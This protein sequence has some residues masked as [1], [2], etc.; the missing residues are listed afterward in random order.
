VVGENASEPGEAHGRHL[1]ARL[2]GHEARLAKLAAEREDV[3]Q[4]RVHPGARVARGIQ[5]ESEWLAHG[6][7]YVRLERHL[8]ASGQVRGEHRERRIR[9]DPSV[10]RPRDRLG[11]VERQPGRVREEMPYRRTGRA[12]GLV[13]VDDTFLGGDD[14]GERGD[15]LRDRGEPER[16]RR[17]STHVY[18]TRRIDDPGSR[19]LDR[20]VVDLAKR[21]HARRY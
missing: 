16:T 17:L 15:G 8:G 6:F 18:R 14:K 13:E 20:P 19:E 12:G 9:V 4:G 2:L 5:G 3:V 11:A 21:L 7:P 1:V 10:A